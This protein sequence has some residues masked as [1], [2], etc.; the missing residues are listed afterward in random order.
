MTCSASTS[1]PSRRRPYAMS[2]GVGGDDMAEEYIDEAG[3]DG[4]GRPARLRPPPVVLPIMQADQRPPQSHPDESLA[5]RTYGG[6]STRAGRTPR[7]E[8]SGSTR[9]GTI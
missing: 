8:Y 2:S 9:T 5:R 1:R 6:R 4:S 7:P 3:H